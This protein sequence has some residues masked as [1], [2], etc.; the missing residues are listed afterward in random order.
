MGKGQGPCIRLVCTACVLC[1]YRGFDVVAPFIHEWTYE[2][3]V[4]DL[5]TLDGNSYK[6]VIMDKHMTCA[7]SVKYSLLTGT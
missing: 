7:A 5:L 1:S 2:S 6:Y 3:V 4:Y